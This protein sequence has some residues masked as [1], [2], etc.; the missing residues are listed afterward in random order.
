MN[1]VNSLI[2]LALHNDSKNNSSLFIKYMNAQISFFGYQ[3]SEQILFNSR[4]QEMLDWTPVQCKATLLY[5]W[6]PH[7]P[8]ISHVDVCLWY[9]KA[10]H[11]WSGLAVAG[12]WQLHPTFRE[13]ILSHFSY[14]IFQRAYSRLVPTGFS[15]PNLGWSI[16]LFLPTYSV[17]QHNRTPGCSTLRS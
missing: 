10:C 12:G 16:I 5:R 17:G 14:P 8:R 11:L 15:W 9:R 13:L 6:L 2:W 3:S 7:I 4:V 1:T